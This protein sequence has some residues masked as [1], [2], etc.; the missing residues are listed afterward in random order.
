MWRMGDSHQTDLTRFLLKLGS[1]GQSPRLGHSTKK[2]SK[3][4]V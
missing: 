1:R 2:G 3:D 4:P